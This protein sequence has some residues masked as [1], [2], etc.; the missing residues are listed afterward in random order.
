MN[1]KNNAGFSSYFLTA[2]L[3]A[4]LAA[5][6]G[7]GPRGPA[8]DRD[9]F[10][11]L[12][13]ALQQTGSKVVEEALIETFFSKVGYSGG[14]PIQENG[15]VLFVAKLPEGL[16]APVRLSGDF[17]GWDPNLDPMIQVPGTDLYYSSKSASLFGD[18]SRYKL[19]FE[20]SDGGDIWLADPNA[21]RLDHDELGEIS[22]VR[23]GTEAGHLERYRGFRSAILGNRRD[24]VLYMPPGYAQS[25][26]ETY[27]VLYMHDGQNLYSPEASSG[28]WEVDE[29]LDEF[30]GAGTVTP[31]IVVGI[32]NTPDRIDEYTHVQD[33]IDSTLYGGD[34]PLYLDFIVDEVK[35]FVD[36]R[37]RTRRGREETGLFGSSLGGVASIWAAL[38]RG[39]AFSRVGGMSTTA[40]WGSIGLHEETIIDIAARVPK[41]EGRLYIDSGGGVSGSCYDSDGDGIWDDNPSA[42][43]NYCENLQLSEV[44]RDSGYAEGSDFRYVHEPGA[45][46]NEAAWSARLPGAL[47][48]LFPGTAD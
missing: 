4:V 35:P 27:P 1:R 17:N 28:G 3:F 2:A 18:R 26:S 15:E 14:F 43:D 34:A 25:R 9:R 36:G 13:A 16:F 47:M 31:L 40:G 11:W 37:Y 39:D 29:H 6:G 19:V 42:E 41:F 7:C 8:T 21:R 24:I 32:D 48:Y 44:L 45:Q 12:L 20:S 5:A 46:H 33:Q 30:I 23:G 10:D 38:A 22:I